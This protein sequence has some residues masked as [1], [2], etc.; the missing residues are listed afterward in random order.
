M[1]GSADILA[2]DGEAGA[3]SQMNGSTNP[4]RPQN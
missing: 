2:W 1:G 4:G 3:D